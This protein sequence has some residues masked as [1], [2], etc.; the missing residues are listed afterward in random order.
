MGLHAAAVVEAVGKRGLE[1]GEESLPRKTDDDARLLP[2]F[3]GG[4]RD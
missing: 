4:L 2:A 1:N 3:D